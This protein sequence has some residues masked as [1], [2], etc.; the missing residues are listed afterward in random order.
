M[1]DQYVLPLV[2]ISKMQSPHLAD[3]LEVAAALDQACKDVGFLYLKWDQFNFDYATSLVE[4]AKSI[5]SR[6]WTQ[7][8]ALYW[9][10]Q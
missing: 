4:L 1:Q 8:A 10:I 7:N 5:S 2:D 9:Q 3:R 6:I